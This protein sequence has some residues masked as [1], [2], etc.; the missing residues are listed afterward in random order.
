MAG[1]ILEPKI[2]IVIN[3]ILHINEYG[4][5]AMIHSYI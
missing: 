5:I 3:E 2:A 1:K 4:M